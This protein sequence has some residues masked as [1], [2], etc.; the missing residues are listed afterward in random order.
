M[1]KRFRLRDV[2]QTHGNLDAVIPALV[3]QHGQKDAAAALGVSQY[4]IST[5]LKEHG[6]VQVV[7]YVKAATP[8]M[9]Q[10]S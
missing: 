6:Y 10:A 2:E 5:W 9:E 3:N 4:T 8:E 1:A 7:R